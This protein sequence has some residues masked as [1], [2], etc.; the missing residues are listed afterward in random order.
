MNYNVEG[1]I[2]AF[3]S[4]VSMSTQNRR[5]MFIRTDTFIRIDTVTVVQLRGGNNIMGC[6]CD[7]Q[8]IHISVMETSSV[9]DQ[10]IH[11]SIDLSMDISKK[12][13]LNGKQHRH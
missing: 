9:I 11:S 3:V 10:L 2:S 8:I 7:N 12:L 5:G 13:L 4:S 1:F 6:T